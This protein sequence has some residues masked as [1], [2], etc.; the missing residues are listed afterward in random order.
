MKVSWT[1][2][3]QVMKILVLQ[4]MF[5]E[6]GSTKA[7]MELFKCL[8]GKGYEFMVIYSRRSAIVSELGKQNVKAVRIPYLKSTDRG[9]KGVMRQL[10]RLFYLI[11]NMMALLGMLVVAAVYKPQIIHTNVSPVHIGYYLARVLGR[12][13]LWH[14]RE[15]RMRDAPVQPI[16]GFPCFMNL[17]KD[18]DAI[19]TTRALKEYYGLERCKV[20]YDGV[21]GSG[22]Q[23]MHLPLDDRQ[24]SFLFVGRVEESK[25]VGI[26][27][28][29]FA[30]FSRENRQ[31]HLDIVGGYEEHYYAELKQIVRDF[32]IEDRV[33]FWG[34][35][36]DV[37]Q[38]MLERKVVVVSS[39]SEGFGYVTVEAMNS[40]C[41]VIAND[42]TGTKEQLDNAK[43][44]IGHDI[45]YRFNNAEELLLQMKRFVSGD[46]EYHQTLVNEAYQ[47]VNSLYSVER[48]GADVSAYYKELNK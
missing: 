11:V 20:I 41:F 25:G 37:I 33:C 5:Q 16:F 2:D 10:Y 15:F 39:L 6:D 31:W 32:G 23:L 44:A 19:A 40:G 29:A 45:A 27:I 21:I 1:G 13:H 7:L 14:L 9:Y 24:D 48:Y 12:P 18:S 22:P 4:Y 8:S 26:L 42:N 46:S 47:I 28:D 3:D 34:V 36:K 38:K 43:Y 30:K 35:C 17:L